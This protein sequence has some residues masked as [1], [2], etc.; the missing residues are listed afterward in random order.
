MTTNKKIIVR[1]NTYTAFRTKFKAK[2]DE[3][4]ESYFDRVDKYLN[5]QKGGK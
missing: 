5:K 4:V 3:T 2:K 1:W